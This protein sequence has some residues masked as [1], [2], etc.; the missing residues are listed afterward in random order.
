[1][2]VVFIQRYLP[3]EMLG[4]AYLATGLKR[5]GHDV[6]VLL[7]PDGTWEQK[8]TDMKPG[9]IGVSTTTGD[10]VF[11]S[12][13][14]ARVKEL[15]DAPIVFG[16][17]HPTFVP[18]LVMEPQIDYVVRGEGEGAVVELADA[19]Q[20]G[21]SVEGIQN[22]SFVRDGQ[23]VDNALRA[24]VQDLDALGFP[25]REPLYS[26]SPLYQ[27]SER[28]VFLTQ[29]GCPYSCSFCFHHVWRDKLYGAKNKQYLRKHS[30]DFTISE[31]NHVRARSPLK[32]VHFLDDIFNMDNEWLEEFCERFPREVGLPFDVILRTNLVTREHMRMLR[33][34]GCISA[35][36]AFESASDQIRN[37]LYRKATTIEQL[38]NS[39]KFVK[40]EG[41]RL[42]T[43]N[44]LGAPGATIE[45]ELQT[46][47]L[48]ID[49]RVDHP[50]CSMLQPYPET[51]INELTREMGFAVDATDH[52]PEKFNRTTSIAFERRHEIENLHKLFPIVVRF[53]FLL[54]LIRPAIRLRGISKICLALYLLWTEYLVCE[55][56][57]SYAKA[58]KTSGFRSL[59]PVEFLRRVSAKTGIKLREAMFG[60]RFS[61]EK[62][63]LL[64]EEDTIAHTGG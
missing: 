41:I 63:R 11:Y 46:L 24:L 38:R 10:H 20:A 26:A 50:L 22:L 3:Q 43:L 30:V 59:P 23:R 9:L 54:P 64:M 15:T 55:Q 56:N 17:P 14:A 57:Q 5:A 49:C 7:L 28:K 21:A 58:T 29:R 33:A 1:M 40:E 2:R 35:R 19:L 6:E 45:D 60:R 51:D 37:D 53:P 42:T 8:L 61:Q 4:H 16:G 32:F 52:F 36:L 48:N 47:E 31:I 25:D 12:K 34:A 18:D 44:L 13:V 62:L 27:E 39:A